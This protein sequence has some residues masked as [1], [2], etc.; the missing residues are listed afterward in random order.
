MVYVFCMEIIQSETFK[1][2]LASIR[3]R[4]TLMRINARIR[5]LS[6]GNFG[7]MKPVRDKVFEL[8]VDC[9]P[10]YRLYCTRCGQLTIILLA[11]GDKS[12]QDRDIEKAIIIAKAWRN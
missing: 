3:D 10:G 4:A 5:R 2:W 6:V 9:G 11:G 8:R 7:D 12:T 1:Q